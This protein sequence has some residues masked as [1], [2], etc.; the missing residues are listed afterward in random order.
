MGTFG[1]IFDIG[2]ASGPILAGILIARYDYLPAFWFMAALL[3]LAVL[4]FVANVKIS[5]T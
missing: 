5:R 1:T 3:I 2:H 4:L